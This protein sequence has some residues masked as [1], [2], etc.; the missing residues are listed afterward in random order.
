MAMNGRGAKSS[1]DESSPDVDELN[2]VVATPT[3]QK[4]NGRWRHHNTYE[5]DGWCEH[6]IK[7]KKKRVAV[8]RQQT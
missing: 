6:T 5:E 3:T 7:R 2:E 1:S 4:P 8:V